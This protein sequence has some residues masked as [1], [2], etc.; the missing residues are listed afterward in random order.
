MSVLFVAADLQVREINELVAIQPVCAGFR[1]VDAEQMHLTLHYIGAVDGNRNTTVTDVLGTVNARVFS[2]VVD[3]V[4]QFRGA[5]GAIILWAGINGSAELL[6]LHASVGRALAAER[7]EME[8]RP[9]APHVTL[10]RC[11]QSVPDSVVADFLSRNQGLSVRPV[12]VTSF[13]LYS[14][15]VVSGGAPTYHREKTYPLEP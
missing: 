14:S 13:S 3:G 15:S 12:S 4:G 1:N 6:D 5:D 11:S 9:Y 2:I 10:G 8:R 7:F